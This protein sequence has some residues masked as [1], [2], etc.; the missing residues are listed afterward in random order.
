MLRN[1]HEEHTTSSK[2]E[3]EDATE[4]SDKVKQVVRGTFP[5]LGMCIK[6]INVLKDSVSCRTVGI[7]LD[8]LDLIQMIVIDGIRFLPKL[9]P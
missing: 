6:N 1:V 9:Y 2:Q 4:V 3:L 5:H 8:M 7:A